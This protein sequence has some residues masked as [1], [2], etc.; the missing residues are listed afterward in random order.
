MLLVVSIVSPCSSV[1]N[2][3]MMNGSE[4]FGISDISVLLGSILDAN[5]IFTTA[6]SP[7]G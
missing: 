7:V 4:S 6:V 3:W 2:G 1:R 5:I